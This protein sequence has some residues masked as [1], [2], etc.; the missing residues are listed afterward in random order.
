MRGRD[1]EERKGAER[2]RSLAG[3]RGLVAALLG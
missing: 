3:F 1:D 2:E